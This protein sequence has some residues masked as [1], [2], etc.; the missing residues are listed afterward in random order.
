MCIHAH[1]QITLRACNNALSA[2]DFILTNTGT[3]DD[4]GIIRNTF[5]S[6]PADFAQSCNSGTCEVRLIWSIANSRWEIQLDNDGPL[7]NPDYTTGILYYNDEAS[8]PNPPDLT[9]GT[10]VDN[11]G[12]TCGGDGSF[13]TLTGDVQSSPTLSVN[14]LALNNAILIYP[15]PSSEIIT[16]K[17]NTALNIKNISIIDVRGKTLKHLNI[18]DLNEQE[19]IN[20]QSLNSG[21]YFLSIISDQGTSTRKLIVN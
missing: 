18:E 14:D 12:G 19:T 8:Y 5:E 2:Q 3:V 20:I 6:A 16:I 10:W 13:T 7:S 11:L 17:N 15:N 1:S 4:G 21:L 9:L